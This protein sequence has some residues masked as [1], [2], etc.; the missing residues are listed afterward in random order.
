MYKITSSGNRSIQI[1]DQSFLT[2]MFV[3][4]LLIQR[5]TKTNCVVLC[6]KIPVARIELEN[7]SYGMDVKTQRLNDFCSRIGSA[8]LCTFLLITG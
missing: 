3:V 7:G 2:F 6:N 5:F 8:R 4:S 1:L